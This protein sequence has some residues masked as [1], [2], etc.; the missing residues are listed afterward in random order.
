MVTPDSVNLLSEACAAGRPVF[1]HVE[2][3]I[4][5]K[6][7]AFHHELVA[8]GRVRPL[9]HQPTAWTPPPPVLEAATVAAEIWRRFRDRPR[10]T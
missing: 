6:L 5:G 10:R 2:R 4:R 3:P 7:A 9:K 8:S 1:T